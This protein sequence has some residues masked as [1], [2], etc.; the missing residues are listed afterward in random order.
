M[1]QIEKHINVSVTSIKN[2]LNE[3]N[4]EMRKK[5]IVS[6]FTPEEKINII[7]L[8]NKF[9]T[10][11]DLAI[12]FNCSTD[13]IRLFLTKNNIKIRTHGESKKIKYE[14]SF[15]DK[16]TNE[17]AFVLGVIFGD[18]H[19]GKDSIIIAMQDLDV[20]NKID[21]IFD[22][23]LN[24]K[25]TK[26][27]PY[28]R[29]YSTKLIN[30][31]TDVYKLCSNKSDKLIFPNINE[32][33]LP[34]FISGYLAADGCVSY[35]KL[36]ECSSLSFSSC[37]YEFLNSLQKILIKNTEIKDRNYITEHK[38]SKDAFPSN[39]KHYLLVLYKKKAIACCNYIFNSTTELTRCDRKYNRYVDYK[40]LLDNTK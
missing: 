22:N 38:Q 20:I 2:I 7:E 31:L 8:Y 16:L 15:V 14:Y 24:I 5:E 12:L 37:S 32:E 21:T 19:L 28:I 3:A 26:T 27:T 40:K 30:E 29:I 33:L 23:S 34:F 18:G 39:K 17:M 11:N 1:K 25:H 9:T 35:N 13:R 10:I 4:I 6:P 36:W